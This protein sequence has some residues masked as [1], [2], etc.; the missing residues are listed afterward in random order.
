MLLICLLFTLS[1][2]NF[3]GEG[4]GLFEEPPVPEVQA[5][6]EAVKDAVFGSSGSSN[7]KCVCC[8]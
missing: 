6:Q 3:V 8:I 2:E 5:D 1:A 4:G 7:G